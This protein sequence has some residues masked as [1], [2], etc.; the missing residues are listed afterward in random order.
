MEAINNSRNRKVNILETNSDFDFG[1]ETSESINWIFPPN[2]E[3]VWGLYTLE[4]T[5]DNVFDGNSS[6]YVEIEPGGNMV[7]QQV[8]LSN[9]PPQFPANSTKTYEMGSWLYLEDL[10]STPED[11]LQPDLRFYWQPAFPNAIPNPEFNV[12]FPANE[13]VYRFNYV[14]FDETGDFHFQIRGFN[15]S[16]PETLKFYFDNITLA[17]VELRP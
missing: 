7:T 4:I 3:A 8:D 1:F 6:A 14:T 13:W 12:D 2:W 5:S 17:E 9:E 15:Q 10:G 11:L 16:N